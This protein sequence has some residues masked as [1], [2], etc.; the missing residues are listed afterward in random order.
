MVRSGR[1]PIAL[2]V[3]ALAGLT[4]AAANADVVVTVPGVAT[5]RAAVPNV[6]INVRPDTARPPTTIGGGI[7]GTTTPGTTPPVTTPPVTTP[8]VTTPPVTTPP[9][10]N[11]ACTATYAKSSEWSGGFNATVTVTAG[12]AAISGWTVRWTWANGQS[13][14]SAWNATVTAS[15]SAI[16]ATNAS[17]NG[18]LNTGQSTSFGF[19]GTWNG[20]NTA[21]TLTC[22]AS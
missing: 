8:P 22:T 2:A 20:T 17:Y 10:G 15:G 16:T 19:N 11:G 4:A 6:R 9:P 1:L 21:P 12:S 7:G 13:I 3:L 5:V 18:R 14:T